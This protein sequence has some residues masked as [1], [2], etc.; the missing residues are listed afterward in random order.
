MTNITLEQ[1]RRLERWIDAGRILA[2]DPSAKVVCPECDTG[3]LMVQDGYAPDG[4]RFERWMRCNV[5][6]HA[7][8]M[9]MRRDED[10]GA[11]SKETI[12]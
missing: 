7:N 11:S 5:C 2:Q 1:R 9:L 6:G 4:V 8:T 12:R 10:A 3:V